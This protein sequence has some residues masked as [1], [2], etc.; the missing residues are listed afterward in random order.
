MNQL[1]ASMS[2]SR[3]LYGLVALSICAVAGVA[4]MALSSQWDTLRAGRQAELNLLTEAASSVIERY[5]GLSVAKKMPEDEA[6]A[7]ALSE[8]SAMRFDHGNYIFV[9]D[10][11]NIN[12]AH[13]DQAM[14]GTDRGKTADSVG[15]NYTAD[16]VPRALRD[17]VATVIYHFPR[18][19]ETKPLSKLS[20]Y[21]SYQPWGWMIASGA[22][23]D[24]IEEQFRSVA[25]HIA[26]QGVAALMV[27]LFASTLVI[28]SISGPLRSLR[29]SMSGLQGGDVTSEVPYV[30]FTSEIGAIAR[31]VD[32]FKTAAIEKLRI[33]AV[34]AELARETD[35]SRQREADAAAASALAQSTVVS[36]LAAGLKLLADGDL[37]Y[38]ISKPFAL[39]YESLRADFNAASTQLSATLQA[40]IHNAS[41]IRLGTDEI[42]SAADDLSRRTEQQAASLEQTAAAL[43]QITAII[44][45][46][47]EGAGH[48]K[49][50]VGTARS[51]A[52]NS[53][54][55]VSQAVEA[56]SGIEA[57]AQ[58]ISR[59]IGV[60]DEIA[61]QT[62]LLALNAGV[63]AAR[64]GDSGRGFA[65]V[66][67]EVR[68]LAH[69]S[70]SAAKE[71]K[72]LILT[73]NPSYSPFLGVSGIRSVGR[74]FPVCVFHR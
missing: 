56:M 64:V 20:V 9:L 73:S 26:L 66:A 46:T 18:P 19:G 43:D 22:Y 55:V 8:V 58:Q 40:V 4:A 21:R 44:K 29:A 74:G 25:W 31:A 5:H 63:E 1:L 13:P 34:S 68:A 69:R 6:K 71:I 52:Q 70:A 3:R 10:S 45:K 35:L 32:A 33:E 53:S 12:V 38:R 48:A 2:I 42:A 67:S 17:G 61:F 50:V 72:A 23:I 57:S 28:R 65:V 37:S 54:I 47:S 11:R 51:D 15:F 24:D 36:G 41:T 49:E 59:I 27:L 16:V 30:T 60:I 62:N 39:Q 14:I 7:A